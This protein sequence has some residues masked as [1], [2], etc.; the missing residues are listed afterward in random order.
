MR[1]IQTIDPVKWT[2]RL[3]L[4]VDNDYADGY[5]YRVIEHDIVTDERIEFLAKSLPRA[6]WIAVREWVIKPIVRRTRS[7]L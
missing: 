4:C 6:V 1:S 3:G 7:S 5:R 2:V